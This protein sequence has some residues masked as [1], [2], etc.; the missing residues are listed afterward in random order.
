MV[1]YRHIK[2]GDIVLNELIPERQN[3]ETCRVKD[4]D[5]KQGFILKQIGQLVSAMHKIS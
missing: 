5:R 3:L 1:I 2:A 4:E